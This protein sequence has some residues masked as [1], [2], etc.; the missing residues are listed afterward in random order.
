M[1]LFLYC[2]GKRDHPIIA[3]INPNSIDRGMVITSGN[4]P[5]VIAI[6]NVSAVISENNTTYFVESRPNLLAA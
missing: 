2:D 4:R 3:E 1:N 6:K 5:I